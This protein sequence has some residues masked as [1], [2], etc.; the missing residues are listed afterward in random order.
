MPRTCIEQKKMCHSKPHDT[1]R[2]LDSCPQSPAVVSRSPE[3]N[4]LYWAESFWAGRVLCEPGE[5][6]F[7][8]L[9]FLVIFSSLA[10]LERVFSGFM[11]YFSRFFK[12]IQVRYLFGDE[13]ATHNSLVQKLFGGSRT[14]GGLTQGVTSLALAVLLDTYIAPFGLKGLPTK[15]LTRGL[16]PAKARFVLLDKCHVSSKISLHRSYS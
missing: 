3:M 13:K 12:Q 1:P 7:P 9:P 6:P 16:Q 10:L 8:V 4:L 15:P 11:F 2:L 14:T 5:V